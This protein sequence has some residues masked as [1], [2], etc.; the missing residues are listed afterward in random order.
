MFVTGVV[1]ALTASAVAWAGDVEGSKDHPRVSRFKGSVITK[2][3]AVEFG[4]T[5]LFL[6]NPGAKKTLK[7]E[8]KTTSITYDILP[9][10]RHT[11]PTGAT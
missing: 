9:G 8:G 5:E 4:Q 10:T 6:A 3:R 1:W 7:V 11:R 2:H